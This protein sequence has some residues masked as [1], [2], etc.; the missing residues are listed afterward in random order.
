MLFLPLAVPPRTPR[1]THFRPQKSKWDGAC[2]PP[3]S[4][5][6]FARDELLRRSRRAKHYRERNRAGGSPTGPDYSACPHLVTAGEGSAVRLRLR[7]LARSFVLRSSESESNR[8]L[9]VDE[10]GML[11]LHHQST[12]NMC[13]TSGQFPAKKKGG[14]H[15]PPF[16]LQRMSRDASS[17]DGLVGRN[18]TRRQCQALRRARPTMGTARNRWCHLHERHASTTYAV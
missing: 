16:S 3:H 5:E 10:T 8:H 14:A 17:H 4:P 2:A 1:L 15:A 9:R 11:P 6:G 18:A 12:D 7:N 13:A